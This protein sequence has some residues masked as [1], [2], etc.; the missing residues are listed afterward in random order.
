MNYILPTYEDCIRI[1]NAPNSIFY[2][3]KSVVD[4]YTISLFNYRIAIYNEFKRPLEDDDINGLEL[5]GLT[6]VFNKD[7]S[8]YK[9]FL[10]LQKFFNLNQTEDSQYDI[11]KNY[12]IKD[13]HNKEDGSVASFIELPNGKVIGKSK[14]GLSSEQSVGINRIYNTNKEIKEFVDWTIKRNLT[15]IFEYVAP[16]NRIVLN[17]K[18]EELILL[19]VRDNL[20]GRY[21]DL[22]DIKEHIGDIRVT[23]TENSYTLD[24]LIEMRETIE[25]KEGWVIHSLTED[26][27]DFFFKLKTKWYFDL[28]GLFTEDLYREHKIVEYILNEE[29]DDI[30]TQIPVEETESIERIDRITDIVWTEVNKKVNEIQNL[31][32]EYV[33]GG[34]KIKEFALEYRKD[35]NFGYVMTL[36]NGHDNVYNIAKS[37]FLKK[38]N[39]LEICREWLREID[40]SIVI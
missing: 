40:D 32:D 20:T 10:L 37:H 16:H 6:F 1:C 24:D 11:V 39:K 30:I 31:Y 27:D 21:I 23:P 17:Y 26:G 34:Y 2:E 12:K 33:N 25:D 19:R 22:E 29:I 35:P 4:G 7:G 28:H 38:Y 15:A 13:I 5:R 36:I 14:M 8:V 18:E 9:R 3:N